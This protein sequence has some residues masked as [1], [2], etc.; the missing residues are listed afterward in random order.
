MKNSSI[1]AIQKLLNNGYKTVVSFGKRIQV[2]LSKTRIKQL[3][4]QLRI[5]RIT[6]P[7]ILWTSKV[8]EPIASQFTGETIA[9]VPKPVQGTYSFA[10]HGKLN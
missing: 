2:P 5:A 10:K 4:N 9:Y 3:Q 6:E 7:K 8:Y 1:K